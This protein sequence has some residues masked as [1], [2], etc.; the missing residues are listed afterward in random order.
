MN[1]FS[2]NIVLRGGA[3]IVSEDILTLFSRIAEV[4]LDSFIFAKIETLLEMSA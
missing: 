2:T 1:C 4:L 3:N